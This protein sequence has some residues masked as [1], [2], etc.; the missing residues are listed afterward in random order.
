MS[1]RITAS[2]LIALFDEFPDAIVL[3]DSDGA[4]RRA[5]ERVEPMFGYTP[6]ELEG[7]S[8]EAL[9]PEADRDRHPA[10]RE[11]YLEDPGTRSMGADLDLRARRKDGSTFPVDINLSQI[12][13]EDGI[14]VMASIR[15]ISERETLQRKYRAVMDAAPDPMFIADAQTGELLE[16]NRRAEALMEVSEDELVGRDQTAL[17][18]NE[19]TERYR[20]LFRRYIDND[21][22]TVARFPN[23]DELF[24]ETA[25]GER[26][27]V[28]I[29]A[30]TAELN[31]DATLIGVFR[32]IS[33]RREYERELQRQIERLETLAQVF[34]HDLR[35][36]LNVA[37][38][39][40][41]LARD[42]GD[43]ERLER[44]ETAHTRMES[45]IDDTLTLIREGYEIESVEPIEL[46]SISSDCWEHVQT[47]GATLRIET[48]G[49]I[50]AD[51]RRVKNLFE[52]LFRN[53]VEHGGDTVT[54]RVGMSEDGFR[55][56]DDGPGIPPEERED[57]LEP[58]WTTAEDGTGLGLNIVSEIASAHGWDIDVFESD[59]GGA[60]FDFTGVKTVVYD[61]SFDG[62]GET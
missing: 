28:E 27:P 9:V 53:A 6:A 48:E 2:R 55:V 1:E 44:V 58:G 32:D 16:V 61:G 19:D 14:E 24:V 41:D 10:H 13:T 49:I 8:V 30:Q 60:R 38:A 3:V 22:A 40:V 46:A 50:Y 52:N 39:G 20:E 37:Q 47:T 12:E 15:D 51:A 62:S 56:A 25:S 59:E 7:M 17:H 35:N 54:V 57:V 5:N 18:P 26:V 11:S 45:L 4:I 31:G 34:S 21:E 33:D 43:T 42:T 29:S 23:G 36:P